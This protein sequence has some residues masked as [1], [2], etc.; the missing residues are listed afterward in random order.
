MTFPAA[1][2]LFDHLRLF[3]DLPLIASMNWQWNSAVVVLSQEHQLAR[4]PSMEPRPNIGAFTH[5]FTAV[6]GELELDCGDAKSIVDLLARW[7]ADRAHSGGIEIFQ[8]LT[9][10]ATDA[11]LRRAIESSPIANRTRVTTSRR[12]APRS[13][14]WSAIDDHLESAM[15]MF[16]LVV[17]PNRAPGTAMELRSQFDPARSERERAT[18]SPDATP[19][20]DAFSAYFE[21]R[22]VEAT[23]VRVV[24]A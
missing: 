23:R 16:R 5:E 15:H 14:V 24:D 6:L 22:H 20:L 17:D 12:R 2:C 4:Y 7:V 3:P 11:S 1:Q 21:R 9:P 18:P 19:F 13:K 8:D 10:G